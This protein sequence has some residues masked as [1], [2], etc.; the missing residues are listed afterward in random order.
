MFCFSISLQNSFTSILQYYPCPLSFDNS[1]CLVGM[2]L[3]TSIISR[4]V[5][6]SFQITFTNDPQKHLPK[7]QRLMTSTALPFQNLA[8]PNRPSHVSNLL[9]VLTSPTNNHFPHTFMGAIDFFQSLTFSHSCL[10]NPI[11]KSTLPSVCSV[12]SPLP[13]KLPRAPEKIE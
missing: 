1:L 5:A 3:Y 11:T 9:P 2:K 7:L 6:L 8:D 4:M 13:P 10:S 12:C